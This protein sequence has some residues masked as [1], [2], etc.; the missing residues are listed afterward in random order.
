[1]DCNLVL[2]ALKLGSVSWPSKSRFLST[3]VWS[4]VLSRLIRGAA[5]IPPSYTKETS[6]PSKTFGDLAGVWTKK[7]SA[8]VTYD[9]LGRS[10]DA[11]C[12]IKPQNLQCF[13]GVSP[14]KSPVLCLLS[15]KGNFF[16]YRLYLGK[17]HSLSC[18]S[19]SIG[20]ND[21]REEEAEWHLSCCGYHTL[22]LYVSSHV[23]VL[24]LDVLISRN[25]D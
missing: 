22:F 17:G 20:P 10:E 18:S 21:S 25:K 1:M 12:G 24:S 7:A 14:R 2:A 23:L 4:A 16:T 8:R 11:T 3:H 19:F 15:T 6:K 5:A 9:L 13:P